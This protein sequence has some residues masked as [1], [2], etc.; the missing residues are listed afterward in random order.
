ML[1]ARTI[2]LGTAAVGAGAFATSLIAARPGDEHSL[3]PVPAL[4]G[5][6]ASALAIGG[7]LGMAKLA[8]AA[9]RPGA[10]SAGRLIAAAGGAALVGTG[11]GLLAA[12]GLSRRVAHQRMHEPERA[13]D[14]ARQREAELPE[15]GAAAE[16][17]DNGTSGLEQLRE[18]TEPIDVE[19]Q[20]D[21]GRIDLV[22]APVAAIARSI[23]DQYVLVKDQHL[24]LAQMQRSDGDGRTFSIAPMIE[25]MIGREIDAGEWP[26]LTPADIEAWLARELDTDDSGVIDVDEAHAWYERTGEVDVTWDWESLLEEIGPNQHHDPE[27]RAFTIGS[28]WDDT[29]MLALVGVEDLEAA[30]ARARGAAAGDDRSGV[31]LVELPAG[32]PATYALASLL[33]MG[34]RSFRG[35]DAAADLAADFHER[36]VFVTD[37]EDDVELDAPRIDRNA[38]DAVD[39]RIGI[40]G[41]SIAGLAQQLLRAYDR[42]DNGLWL[43][44]LQR[45]VDDHTFSILPIL[46]HAPDVDLESD[47][48]EDYRLDSHEQLRAGAEASAASAS[49]D[50]SMIDGAE[51]DA[52]YERTGEVDVTWDWEALLDDLRGADDSPVGTIEY[53]EYMSGDGEF[54]ATTMLALPG[55]ESVDEAL[56]FARATSKVNAGMSAVVEL[57]DDAP[58]RYAIV[59]MVVDGSYEIADSTL[60]ALEESGVSILDLVDDRV[61]AVADLRGTSKR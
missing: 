51:V 49:G 18:E 16:K 13:L 4:V 61:V 5:I 1:D 40:A 42:N 39:G 44:E 8:E 12:Y 55:V 38:D 50:P 24:S 58:V 30:K 56:A 43:G 3:R 53:K 33:R 10:A 36:V 54:G 35:I 47:S 29:P 45:T 9:L 23:H 27:T 26:Q 52:W 21:D 2:A 31:A 34:D 19:L 25:A 17:L 41:A 20:V 46:R 37:G 6:A 32:A 14:A 15:P 57:P 7:G 59:P 28:W 11:T 22:G 48:K 60:D